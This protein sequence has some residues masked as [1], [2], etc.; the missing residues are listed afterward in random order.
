M[1][2]CGP[3]VIAITQRCLAPMLGALTH[4]NNVPLPLRQFL[5]LQQPIAHSITAKIALLHKGVLGLVNFAITLCNLARTMAAPILQPN[6]V[7]APAMTNVVLA[8][9]VT[10]E[11][12]LRVQEIAT[13]I[14]TQI[15]WAA[16]RIP[17]ACGTRILSLTANPKSS[18]TSPTVV[19]LLVLP[20]L[21]LLPPRA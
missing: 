17:T 4:H 13:V 9:D 16:C 18:A 6:V 1:D 11:P 5:P 3:V 21:L 2:A 8:V 10:R 12:V 14:I 15:V 7:D 20:P 19:L